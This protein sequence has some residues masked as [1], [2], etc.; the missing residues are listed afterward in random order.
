MITSTYYIAEAPPDFSFQDKLDY[1]Y[2]SLCRLIELV[3]YEMDFETMQPKPADKI[4][5][6]YDAHGNKFEEKDSA[7][8]AETSYVHT[9]Q[10]EYDPRGNWVKLIRFDNGTPTHIIER[11]I[12]Y[13]ME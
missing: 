13:Y 2:D 4:S 10:Y 9:Y 6:K 1:K 8:E 7:P 3:R 12:T 5:Y 11:E